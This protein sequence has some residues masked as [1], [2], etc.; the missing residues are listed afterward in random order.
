MTFSRD[1]ATCAFPPH[2]DL[3][4]PGGVDGEALPEA[5]LLAPGSA[6]S[7]MRGWFRHAPAERVP[8]AVVP[9]VWTAAEI[10]HAAGVSGL[11]PGAAALA[12]AGIAYGAGEG[13]ARDADEEHPRLRGAE[14]AA[15][16]GAAGAW[17]TAATI[18]GPL[19]GPYDPLSIAYGAGAAIGYWWL[20]R[21]E[22]IRAARRRRDEAAAAAAEAAEREAEWTARKAEWHRLAARVGLRGSHL[23]HLDPNNNGEEWQIDTYSAR[24]LAS[25]VHCSQVAQ[26]LA[27]ELGLRKS[28]VEVHA[29]PDWPYKLMILVRRGDPWK[30]GSADGCIW[31]PWVSGALDPQAPWAEMT[32]EAPSILDPAVIGGDPETGEPLQ[33][34]L[35]TRNGAER[36]LVVAMSGTGKSMTLD[37]LCERITACRDARLLQ[38]NLSKGVEDAWWAPLAEASAL[39]SDPDPAARALRILDFVYDVILTRPQSR[40]PGVR[41]HQPT[42]EEP[43]FVLKIDEVDV[44]A[45]DPERQQRLAEIASKCR[46]E[47]VVLLLGAQRP[48]NKWIG[49]AG[50]RANLSRIVWGKMRAGDVRHAAGGEGIT[51]PDIGSYGG[52]NPGVFGVC[53][54]PTFSGMPFSRGR[55]FHWGEDSPGLMRL[56]AARAATR[57]PYVLEPALAGLADDWAA[58][59]GS[60]PA[61]QPA[62]G[63]EPTPGAAEPATVPVP[64][65]VDPRYDLITTRTGKTV[66]GTAGIRANLAQ[67]AAAETPQI[68]PVPSGMEARA[69]AV[70]VQRRA[71]HL[72]AYTDESAELP[73]DL[74]GPLRAMLAAPG[75]VSIRAAAEQ[76]GI[77][78]DRVHR[79][80][81]RW[82]AQGT[83]VVRG[84]GGRARRWH[85]H[86]PG[87]TLAAYPPLQAVEDAGE[88]RS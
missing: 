38:L 58:I 1:P 32:P 66:P 44:V 4:G 30:G 86:R 79:Q 57:R 49:G 15:V 39:A 74:G 52:G 28:R 11:V 13:H 26:K 51:L 22:A 77:G 35:Y 42:P 40:K 2:P 61:R 68:P 71:E 12:A 14:L 67:A 41:T 5:P 25:Q 17:V 85:A 8:P 80:L 82:R 84:E 31:H 45:A 75:G 72:A 34:P 81:M 27:G 59:T 63:P 88:G 50:V 56:I 60:A 43:A 29:D 19:A 83:A 47:G 33:V 70:L 9:V 48:V 69:A 73:A 21:H 87:D 76:L 37:D 55:S 36:V 10:M 6:L 46:S 23:L 78:R 3:P 7:R 54:H 18:W 64:A 16:T 24:Q 62:A 65:A 53:E 20:R